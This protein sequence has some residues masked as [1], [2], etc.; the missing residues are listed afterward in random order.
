MADEL[1]LLTRGDRAVAQRI[2]DAFSERTGL[3]AHPVTGGVRYVLEGADHRIKIVEILTDIDR[4]WPQ[5]V[6]L[7]QPE[8]DDR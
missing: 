6:A 7:G 4:S 5:H 2:F 8:R 1:L 3:K